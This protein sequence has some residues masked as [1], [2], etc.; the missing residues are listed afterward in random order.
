LLSCGHVQDSP[1][2]SIYHYENQ[3]NDALRLY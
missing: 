3:R 1:E 2:I